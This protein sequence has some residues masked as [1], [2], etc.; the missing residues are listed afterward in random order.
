MGPV[1]LDVQGTEL[2]DSDRQLLCHP[3]VGGVILFSRNYR[4]VAQLSALTAQ[5]HQLREPRLLI[6]VDHE[7][8]RVQRFRDGF[9]ALPAAALIGARYAID[10]RGARTLCTDA[11]WM[12]AAE[13]R[14]CGV[15]MSF[16][17]VLDLGGELSQVIGDRAFGVDPD[18][19]I[20][21][22]R[23]YV[24]G[25]AKAGM[26]AVGKHFPGHG[27]VGADSHVELPVDSRDLETFLL[28]DLRP[29]SALADD[30]LAG[31]M[32]AHLLVPAV[33]QQA[34]SFSSVWIQTVLRDRLGYRGAVFSDDL[35]MHG[36]HQVGTP[37]QRA[38][39]ALRAGCDMVLV[40]NDREAALEVVSGVAAPEQEDAG[41]RVL[42]ASRMA[43]FRQHGAT[44]WP[45]LRQLDRYKQVCQAL[46]QLNCAP[47]LD[48]Y[49]DN[50]A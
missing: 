31:M 23:A 18:Q 27:G 24:S 21:L 19:V 8:G 11:G 1:M 50:P 34:V 37:A 47:E 35:S 4:D 6:A 32:T 49:D 10:P 20:S 17:P 9:T 36:A 40:C 16:A 5:I 7:G 26:A 38:Q 29:F 45:E 42:R 12:M 14:A 46:A 13:L 30:D 22:S 48:L 33:D 2:D 28:E 43:R 3:A 39:A 41:Q 25:M 44:E 15:D